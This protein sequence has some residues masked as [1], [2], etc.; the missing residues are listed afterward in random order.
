MLERPRTVGCDPAL[1]R[2]S[3]QVPEHE[4]SAARLAPEVVQRHEILARDDWV[5][6]WW[7]QDGWFWSKP[8]LNFW[9]QS[10]AMASLGTHYHADMMMTGAGGAWTAHPEWVVRTP[11]VLMTLVA[12]YLLYKGVAKVFGRRAG[13]LGALVLATM[14]DWFFL[15]HQTM[16]DMPFV[17][18]MTGA[19]G[20]LLNGLNTHEDA[21]VQRLRGR[22]LRAEVAPLAVAPR[23]RR[24]AAL[25]AAADP[26]SPL[27]QHRARGLGRRSE[28]LPP[29]LGRVQERLGDELRPP[30]QRSV[31]DART[32]LAS[33]SRS[34]RTRPGCG[35]RSSATSAASSRRCRRVGWSCRARRRA[36]PELG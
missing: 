14:P 27:A 31:R 34:A 35:R 33:R 2:P 11:N 12:M 7:A 22:R 30:R 25:R 17:A 36:L 4:V 16:T 13:L 23:L 19:M 24:R 9:I 18:A 28:G 26:L 5:S 32:G 15:A 21:R 10:L 29:P 8:I 20:L 6:L 3:A 1:G